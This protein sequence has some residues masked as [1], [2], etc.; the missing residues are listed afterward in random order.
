MNTVRHS[1][2]SP[3]PRERSPMAG[4]IGTQLA[5]VLMAVLIAPPLLPV[6]DAHAGPPHALDRDLDSP[7]PRG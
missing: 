2:P 3:S 5:A 4:R 7:A 1:T 6:R